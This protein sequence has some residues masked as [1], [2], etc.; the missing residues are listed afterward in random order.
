M[1]SIPEHAAGF[2]DEAG[3]LDFATRGPVGTAV[4]DEVRGLVDLQARSRFGAG[5]ALDEQAGRVR[6]AVAAV[7]G[8]RADQV[9]FQSSAAEGLLLVLSG[10]TGGLLLPTTSST[11][12]VLAVHGAAATASGPTPSVVR[13]AGDVVTVA[14]LA[15]AVT[16]ETAAVVV[17]LVDPRSGALLD[18]AAVREAVGDRLLVVDAD[19]AFGVVDAPWALADVVVAGGQAGVRAGAGTGFATFSDRALARLRPALRGVAGSAATAVAPALVPAP[20]ADADAHRLGPADPIAQARL[21]TALEGLAE[22]GQ[23]A[24]AAAVAD[25]AARVV[26]L[27][28]AAAMPVLTPRVAAERAGTIV[29]APEPAELTALAAALHN[30]GIT[31]TVREGT[32]RLSVHVTTGEAT[33]GLLRDAFTAAAAGTTWA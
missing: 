5:A 8:V 16:D 19:D 18:L 24:V 1:T 7:V 15:A 10:L 17:S 6:R 23:A 27:A 33:F 20:A 31:A 22:V 21:A 4:A 11:A 3:Y 12:V 2:T 9:A 26:D 32:V 13:P 28:D 14:D 25:R 30:H 29:L